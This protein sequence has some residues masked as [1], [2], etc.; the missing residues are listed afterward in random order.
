MNKERRRD[1]RQINKEMVEEPLREGK[2][3]KTVKKDNPKQRDQIYS[4][5]DKIGILINNRSELM[6]RVREY[7]QELYNSK[8]HIEE[9]DLEGGE[10][11]YLA[12]RG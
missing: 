3:I 12:G 4:L 10:D 1:A 11:T 9:R 8:I 7:Y 6:K 5:K 2:S